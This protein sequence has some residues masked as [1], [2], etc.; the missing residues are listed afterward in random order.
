MQ[1][2]LSRKS[3]KFLNRDMIKYIAM[4]T[5]LLNHIATI[6]LT[7]GTWLC[8]LFIAIGY[9]TAITMI[10]FLVEGYHCTHSK[11]AYLSRLFVFALISEI[12]YC[13]AFT[14]N[15]VME[16]DGLNMMF[17]LC[18]CFGILYVLDTIQSRIA[19]ACLI[20]FG[21]FISLFCDW[22]LLAPIFTIIFGAFNFL[23]GL[24]RFPL[25]TNLL[26]ALLSVIGMGTAAICIL[27]FYNGQR[28]KKG[29]SF[30]KWF[31]YLFYP[32]HLLVLG[33][34]RLTLIA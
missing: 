2:E 33:I 20:I 13:L 19:K 23:G 17:T 32:I 1:T 5:M 18:V 21:V 26:Y 10:Y 25:A 24:G 12:P 6:F 34:L 3:Y 9:F 14:T 16:F 22:A 15:G 27:F 7:P 11:K 28:M 30:S 31:F 29:K 8:E 4:F